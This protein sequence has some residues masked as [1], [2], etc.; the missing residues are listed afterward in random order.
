MKGIVLAGGNGTRLWPCTAGASK[1]LLPVY[2]KP[3]IYYSM[4][5]LLLAGIRE[6][7]IITNEINIPSYDRVFGDGSKL[8]IDISYASQENPNGIA[9]ALII[10]QSFIGSNPVC[11]VLGDNIFWGHGF[12]PLLRRA[13]NVSRGASIF[14]TRSNDPGNFGVVE[15]DDN[16]KVL[17]LEEKPKQ[18]KSDTFITGLY[19]FDAC[20]SE[21]AQHVSPSARGELEIT[22]VLNF[23]LRE[24]SITA[25]LLGRGFAWFDSGTPDR[26]LEAANFVHTVE[27][28]QGVKI[29][30]VEEICWRNGWISDSQLYDLSKLCLSPDYSQYLNSL[31]NTR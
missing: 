12:S 21:I 20:A 13:S 31:L 27:K 25:E 6:I 18:P 9:E 4:A 1:Q 3:M 19:F 16:R 22:S 15:L 24:S 14:C 11:L 5:T 23:Y 26:L 17:S 29:G 8:G 10:G 28:R 7:L 30:C 2:D